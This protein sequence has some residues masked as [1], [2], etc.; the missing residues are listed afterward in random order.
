M[1]EFVLADEKDLELVQGDPSKR[2]YTY[3]QAKA[4]ALIE[5]KCLSGCNCP[6]DMSKVNYDTV[7]TYLTSLKT[8]E[9]TH[10]GMITYDGLR[11]LI[12]HLIK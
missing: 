11:L 6:I 5:A 8:V 3:F 1:S 9:D 2:K 4:M 7:A 12:I 10:K